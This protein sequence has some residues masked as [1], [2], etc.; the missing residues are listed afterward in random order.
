MVK[1]RDS[2]IKL[3][4][5]PRTPSLA[6]L[7]KLGSIVVHA[8]EFTKPGGHEFDMIAM[9]RL[10]DDPEVKAWVK[11]MGAFLPLKRPSRHD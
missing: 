3:E 6:L 7:V 1:L 4:A 2:T 11:L 10:I 5:D 9:R 8:D